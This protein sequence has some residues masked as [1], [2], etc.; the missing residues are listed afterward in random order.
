MAREGHSG[1]IHDFRGREVEDD[2]RLSSTGRYQHLA[3]KLI[4]VASDVSLSKEYC[5]LVEESTNVMCKKIKELRLQA[6]SIYKNKDDAVALAI[7]DDTQPKGFK[8][9][10]SIKRH[11]QKNFKSWSVLQLKKKKKA[12]T[13]VNHKVKHLRGM[14]VC[15]TIHIQIISYSLFFVPCYNHMLICYE[16]FRIMNHVKSSLRQ[17][18]VMIYLKHLRINLGSHHS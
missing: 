5:Q 9:R 14:C 10:P 4:R 13:R 2:P 8:K 6:H 3:S 1:I 15:I 7:N 12:L 17:L 18:H 11:N 16:N